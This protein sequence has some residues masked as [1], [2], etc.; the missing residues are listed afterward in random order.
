[1]KTA[2]VIVTAMLLYSAG[3]ATG[4][5]I[6]QDRAQELANYYFAHQFP[7]IGCGGAK[8]PTLRDDYWESP[9][10]IGDGATPSGTIRVHRST[11]AVSYQGP[12]GRR[13]SVSAESLDRW[14]TRNNATRKP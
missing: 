11:G 1:M 12:L 7:R 13:P 10:A 2:L 9:V 4:P 5:D 3:L 14:A 6:T 8:R